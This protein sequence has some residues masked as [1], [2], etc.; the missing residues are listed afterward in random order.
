MK[1]RVIRPASHEEW[2]A[3]RNKGIGAS[4]VGAI[5]GISPFETP[6]SLWLK[7]TG[8]VPPE[9]ENMAM[10]LGHLLEPAVC[11]L[12]EEATGEKVIKASAADIIYVH[13]EYDYMRATPDRIVRG[14]KKLVEIKTTVTQ[15]DPEDIYPHWIAQCQMQMYVTGIHDCDLAYLVQ[16]RYFGYV[17]VPYD[18]EFAEFIAERV[19]EFWNESVIGGK[20]PDLISVADFTMKG[21]EPG[22]TIDADEETLSHLLSTVELN[23]EI[24][25]AE[26]AR[27]AHKDAVKLY[28][29][30][31]E[32]LTVNG[33]AIATWK[34]G[35]RGRI[36]LLKKNNIEE[37]QNNNSE[38]VLK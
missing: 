33:K 36:F 19:K 22:T 7:K 5:L 13:P 27:D 28:M 34:T 31:A 15:V 32:T 26:A 30:E 21:S 8:Q 20:E 10:K 12:W 38:N 29:G 11:Q 25:V 1:P 17:H 16:G 24:A 6:F 14:R 9:P 35:A 4:E 37:I 23:A 3:E 2:L 18:P